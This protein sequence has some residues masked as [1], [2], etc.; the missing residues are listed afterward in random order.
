MSYFNDIIKLKDHIQKN[1]L[2][3]IASNHFFL[4]D[5]AVLAYERREGSSRQPYIYDGLTAWAYACGYIC[6]QD[7]AYNI[8][9][10]AVEGK[11]PNIAFFAN[12]N[13]E[14]ISLLGIPV[15]NESCVKNRYTVFAENAVYYFTELEDCEFVVRMF[16]SATKELYFS[17]AVLPRT[18][19][20]TQITISSY[21]NPYLKNDNNSNALWMRYFKT[22]KVFDNKTIT[23]YVTEG[24]KKDCDIVHEGI[25]QAEFENCT[26]LY[27][28]QTTKKAQFNGGINC[29][30]NN[31]EVA[32][33]CKIDTPIHCTAFDDFAIAG[34]VTTIG[35][36]GNARIE[37]RFGFNHCKTDLSSKTVDQLFGN[38]NVPMKSC[39]D[40]HFAKL[41]ASPFSGEVFERFIKKIQYQ[42]NI[43]ALGKD[44]GGG[45]NIGFR[46]IAQQIEQALVWN[47]EKSRSQI[48][49]VMSHMFPDGRAPRSFTIPSKGELPS[50]EL[51]NYI[52]MGIWMINAI[53]QYLRFTG[54]F[55]LL[56]EVCGYYEIGNE[57]QGQIR[58]STIT[59]SILCHVLRIAD[60][61]VRNIAPDTGC[62]QVLYADWNDAINSLG[63]TADEGKEFGTG[64][65][66]MATFQ[67]YENF[68]MVNNMLKQVGKFEN[69][70]AEYNAAMETIR[71]G[72][73]QYAIVEKDGEY[74][75]VHGWGD[76]RN[77][78][79]GSFCDIDGK[80]RISSTSVSFFAA[81]TL[82]DK[83]YDRDILSAFDRLDSKYGLRTFDVG[84]D[85]NLKGI[86]RI[87]KLPLGTAENAAVYIHA[88]MFAVHS[89]FKIGYP[90]KAYQHLLK[91]LPISYDKVDK[92]P[93]VMQNAYCYNPEI[94]VYGSALN[95]W[96]TGSAAVLMKII[97]SDLFGIVPDYTGV[98]IDPLASNFLKE[99]QVK[100]VL[101]G[102][103]ITLKYQTTGKP[104]IMLNNTLLTNNYIP[105]KNLKSDNEIVV[106]K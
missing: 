61:L 80:S 88:G 48:L 65:S 12:V 16:V 46:D 103:N 30:L 66:V 64:V 23:F 63:N 1:E 42:V 13:G 29:N 45:G 2:Y 54:D 37:Y 105:F 22:G 89:L 10:E 85:P 102:K 26:I 15:L 51:A 21:F 57:S 67:A 90:E 39:L 92:T 86:G 52:D 70:I 95:D 38:I 33:K 73:F 6:V 91:L 24:N 77:F 50:M 14:L 31:A 81:S 44:M 19:N 78:L 27:R 47:P 87:G 4:K 100:L 60:R 34:D 53:D 71:K 58:R 101:H 20:L 69:K 49:M 36:T 97:V 99:F 98:T 84:F 75:P 3:P 82:Y 56:D 8:F 11:E 28:E 32:R 35:L 59:D 76:K 43:C 7:G 93:F 74:R 40:F 62:I 106:T 104:S 79:V 25:R 5:N 9:P 94:N 18:S 55:S 83:K 68:I 72:V 17:L 41:E 96:I